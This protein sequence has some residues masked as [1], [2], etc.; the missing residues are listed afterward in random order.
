LTAV[1][2]GDSNLLGHTLEQ[3][4]AVEETENLLANPNK[5]NEENSD[6]N[7]EEK[8]K[9]FNEQLQVKIRKRFDMTINDSIEKRGLNRVK[10]DY[11]ID[12][13]VNK[14]NKDKNYYNL[15]KAYSL[16]TIDEKHFL[17]GMNFHLRG[18]S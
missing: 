3:I 4:Q 8:K 9:L 16:K 1:L 10:I 12:L 5:E 11:I 6:D 2:K 15:R 13:L 14:K 7:Y 18:N 17:Y